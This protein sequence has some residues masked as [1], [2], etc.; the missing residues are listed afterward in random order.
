MNKQTPQW[1]GDYEIITPEEWLKI[2][3]FKNDIPRIEEEG[4]NDSLWTNNVLEYMALYAEYVK[5]QHAKRI[6]YLQD[7]NTK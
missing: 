2:N 1:F 3:A 5:T 4:L 7:Y 6:E